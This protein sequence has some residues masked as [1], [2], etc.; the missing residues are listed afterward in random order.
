MEKIIRNAVDIIKSKIDYTPQVA[1][2]IGSGL[3]DIIDAIQDKVEIE[4]DQIPNMPKT[5]VIG[6]KNK[7]VC[8]K[9][10]GKYVIAQ[11]G[12]FHYYDCGDA[13]TTSLP[14]YIFKELGVEAL[15][16]TN[17][18]GAV[19]KSFKVGDLVV[20]DD[21]INFTGQN[22]LIGGAIINYGEQFIDMTEPYCYEYI[23]KFKQ[24][25]KQNQ[26]KVQQGTY[27]QFSGPT[28]E[29]KAE[30]QMAR[31]VGADLVGMSTALEVIVARQCDLKVLGISFISNI[32]TG[33]SKTKTS[34]NEVLQNGK[35]G[36]NKL[37][38]LIPQF[39]EQI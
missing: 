33:A 29:T 18:A 9:L 30:V 13:K 37:I 23:T 6:H 15:I 11:L 34:H 16:I 19:N 20:I 17:S 38:K 7:F 35:I 12:R 27:M 5:S 10:N 4:Y 32:A 28:Y 21:Q 8:G 31:K 14:I 24:I 26:V 25:A 3:G 1:L 39:I 36:V 22:P 2:V